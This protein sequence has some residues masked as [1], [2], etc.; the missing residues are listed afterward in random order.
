MY[1]KFKTNNTIRNIYI[2]HILL[3]PLKMKNI[4][5][6]ILF[7]PVFSTYNNLF[8]KKSPQQFRIGENQIQ[9]TVN[10][11]QCLKNR[12]TQPCKGIPCRNLS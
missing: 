9:T 6:C 2:I 8:I 4:K 11:P 10:G 3:Y 12:M 5:M 1:C 7:D